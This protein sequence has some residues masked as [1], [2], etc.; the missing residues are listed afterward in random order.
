[1]MDRL[2]AVFLPIP[3]V[4]AGGAYAQAHPNRVLRIVVGPG[5][6][7]V[8]RLFS[9][10]INETL[11]QSVIVEQRPGAG[12]VIAAQTVVAAPP[13]GY[14]LLQATASY[15][16]N[17]ALHPSSLDLARA[18]SPVPMVSTTPLVLVLH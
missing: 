14:T 2:R 8:A 15:T 17:T 5:P 1:M 9:S 11:G 7:I 12:G 6:D 18:F 10:K 4:A 13:D 16:I 3:A